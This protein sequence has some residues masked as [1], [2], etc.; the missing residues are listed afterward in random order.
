M[1]SLGSLRSLKASE[2]SLDASEQ[3]LEAS[4]QSLEASEGSLRYSE[5]FLGTLRGQFESFHLGAVGGPY[6]VVGYCMEL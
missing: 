3:S 2:R 5:K 1:V 6:W 4:E